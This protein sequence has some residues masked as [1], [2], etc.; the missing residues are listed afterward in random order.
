MHD[1]GS[2]TGE[3]FPSEADVDAVLC[4]FEGGA[5]QAIRALL[6]DLSVLAGDYEADVSRGFVR[7]E[8]STIMIRRT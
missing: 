8:I 2:Q 4:E 1:V 5:R 6:H 3:P 7:G